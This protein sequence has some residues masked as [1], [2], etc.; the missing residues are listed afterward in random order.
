VEGLTADS[1]A[2]QVSRADRG[3]GVRLTAGGVRLLMRVLLLS[4]YGDLG[5]SSRVRSY[6][7]LPYLERHGVKVT[8]SPLFPNAY[9]KRL[10]A[11]GH[12]PFRIVLESFARRVAK[13]LHSRSHDLV[14]IEKELL[15]MV[16]A[17]VEK[18]LH[19]GRRVP[20]IADYDDAL[21]H[22]Y[23]LHPRRSVRMLLRHKI[24]GVMRE[25]ALV[26]AGNEYLADYAREAGAERVEL[27]PT[28]VDLDRYRTREWKARDE[29]IIGWMGSPVT[30]RYLHMVAPALAKFC[31]G[32]QRVRIV[33]VG[34]GP[35]QLEGVA[36]EVRDWDEATEVA[37]IQQFDVG[38]MP[39]SDTPWERG[40][41]GYKLI[42]C[43]A[44]GVPVIASPVGANQQIVSH[45]ENGYL[46]GD[47]QS[48]L[49]ALS[50]LYDDPGRRRVM[51]A[52]GRSRVEAGYCLQVTAPR[53]LSF[54]RS[55][56]GIPGVCP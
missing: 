17:W 2:R 39:L 52:A 32:R 30:A 42:Q 13:V 54:L 21:F 43:M 46:A 35:I 56:G 8:V 18:L 44:C 47:E 33:L 24:A 38:I 9:L 50:E 1:P 45:T 37:D 25:A 15:P 49:T 41:C 14:W 3:L 19:G 4:R 22:N 11:C 12:R 40:K 34:S 36:A 48:W 23:D 16:P 51:G 6:Q 7:Y 29:F 55:V 53:L 20:F 26:V 10:Y 5:A 28:A 27:L 31:A